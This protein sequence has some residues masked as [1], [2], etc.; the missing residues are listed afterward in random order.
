MGGEVYW[1]VSRYV[2]SQLMLDARVGVDRNKENK[3]WDI[4]VI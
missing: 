3:V 2:L 4:C 1:A